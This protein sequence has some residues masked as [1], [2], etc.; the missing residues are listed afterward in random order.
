MKMK[1]KLFDFFIH[2]Y[3]MGFCIVMGIGN[4]AMGNYDYG[5]PRV[6]AGFCLL[7]FYMKDLNSINTKTL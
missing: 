5:I 2:G 3:P 1:Q 4:L 7:Y 6:I